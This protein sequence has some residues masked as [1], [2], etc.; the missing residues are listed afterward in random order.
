MFSLGVRTRILLLPLSALLPLLLFQACNREVSSAENSAPDS[1]ER[2][3][4]LAPALT[5]IVFSLELGDRLVGITDFCDY[6][7][8]VSGVPRMGGFSNP[9]LELVT[10]AD[11]DL[12]LISENIGNQQAG[13]AM[14]ES[15]LP[16]ERIP[17]KTFEDSFTAIERVGE[18]TGRASIAARRIASIK[19]RLQQVKTAIAGLEKP[20]VV[21]LLSLEPM[22]HAGEDTLPGQAIVKAGGRAAIPLSG[23]PRIGIETLLEANPDILVFSSMTGAGPEE[24]DRVRTFF[25]SWSTLSAVTND[26]IEVFDASRILRP[27]PRIGEGVADLAQRFYPDVFAASGSAKP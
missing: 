8:A 12:I 19:T 22:I 24:A 26:R 14:I 5:E 9:S 15:G 18:L 2:I 23:Y 25:S 16:V 27:G 7:P 21:L 17:G 20:T 3:I 13:L 1:P 6:P 11:P 4:S 10:E